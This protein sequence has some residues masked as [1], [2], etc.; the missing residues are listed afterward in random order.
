LYGCETWSLTL[1]KDHRL[2]IFENRVLRR[3]SGPKRNEITG[4]WRK[5]P[6][7]E[8]HNLPFLPNITTM[9]KSGKM[10]WVG[11]VAC[12]MKKFFWWE[13]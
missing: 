2:R 3:I 9:I 1:K 12:M 6:N 7:E 10:R 4:S 5:L 11:L 8:L 13:N